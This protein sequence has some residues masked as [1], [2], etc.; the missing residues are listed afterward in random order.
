MTF[1]VENLE[2]FLLVVV[3]LA[4]FIYS[5]PIFS[6][7]RIPSKV[8]VGLAVFLGVLVYYMVPAGLPETA[9]L[10]LISYS[11][12]ILQES[13]VGLI[14]GFITNACLYIVNFSGRVIDM[15]LGLS[16]SNMMDPSTRLQTSITGSYYTQM[17]SIMFLVS[18]MH[19]Y[20]VKAIIDSF[21]Y[22]PVGRAII[23]RTLYEIMQTFIVDF[24]LIGFRIVLPV[25]AVT[26]VV[27]IVLGVLTKIAP[28]MNMFVVGMQLKV[29][30]GLFVLLIIVGT[31]P[32]VSNYIFDEMREY[33]GIMMR[34]ITPGS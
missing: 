13:I 28:Q 25:F 11:I 23:H 15:E 31:L 7:T 34:A 16:M 1:T 20:V 12:L 30:V 5:A 22:A 19:Y 6:I 2:F 29:F 4:A 8:K 17:V 24:F 27:N 18:N 3:R 10:G 26:L 9:G 21:V 14:L 33:L 32:T